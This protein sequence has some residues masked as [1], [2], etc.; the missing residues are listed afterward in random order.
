MQH[1]HHSLI[2]AASPAAAHAALTTIAG[3]RAWWTEECEGTAAPGGTI[4]FRFGSVEKDMQVTRSEPGEVRWVCTR[5]HLDV[6]SLSRKDEWVGTE[7]VFSLSAGVAPGTVKL[8]FE[9]IGLVPSVECYAMCTSGW[10]HFLASLKQYLE[11]G[12]GFPHRIA[13][14]CQERSLAA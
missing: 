1:Y 5:A 13:N 14:A 10:Q 11:T 9:H 7:M 4:H 3:L 12:T 6:P 8:Q 2:I